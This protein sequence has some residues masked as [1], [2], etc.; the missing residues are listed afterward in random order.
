MPLDS[1]LLNGLSVYQDIVWSGETIR[2]GTRDCVARWQAMEAHLP[3]TGTVLDVGSNFGWFGLQ[4]CRE[5]PDCVVASVEADPRSAAVQ[6]EV[7]Q[8]NACPRICL[9]TAKAGNRMA[10]RF[11]AA[12]QTFD[13]VFCLSV[14][15]WI[16]DHRQFLATLGAIAGRVFV[17]QPS[18]AEDGAGVERIRREIGPIGPYLGSV[19]PDRSVICLAQWPSH[20]DPRHTRELWLV[21]EPPDWPTAGSPGLDVAGLLS[22]RLSWPPRSWWTDQMERLSPEQATLGSRDNRLLL[23][24]SGLTL[25]QS[26][27]AESLS[28]VLRR[29]GRVPERRLESPR[30]WL[31]R[32]IRRM[33]GVAMRM[34]G[35]LS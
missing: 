31:E 14:L 15:H 7:L 24:P 20:R 29:L 8:S 21:H 25:R 34:L 9:L 11:A 10:R 16:A 27:A 19:F 35:W 6:R 3:A 23:I 32:R 5:R 12:G 18:P 28:R 2:S 30:Q 13:A 26:P 17:E 1:R 33:G 4:V 22:N